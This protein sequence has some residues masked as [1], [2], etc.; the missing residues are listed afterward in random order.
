[1]SDALLDHREE[2]QG[3]PPRILPSDVAQVDTEADTEQGQAQQQDRA[4]GFGQARG[5]DGAMHT[6]DRNGR[7]QNH[8]HR[9]D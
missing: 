7:S 8:G 1:V 6:P 5:R 4:N 9:V 3:V 2:S